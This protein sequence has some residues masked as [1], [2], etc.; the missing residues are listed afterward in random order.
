MFSLTL[1]KTCQMTMTKKD[2]H[3]FRQEASAS[4]QG[5]PGYTYDSD[6]LEKHIGSHTDEIKCCTEK[7]LCNPYTGSAAVKTLHDVAVCTCCVPL[8]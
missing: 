3:N 2:H 5:N 6:V 1:R 4:V 8:L 7:L